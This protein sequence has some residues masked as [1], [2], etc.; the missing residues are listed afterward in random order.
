MRSDAKSLKIPILPCPKSALAAIPL[1]ALAFSCGSEERSGP[2]APPPIR[3]R[4]WDDPGPVRSSDSSPALLIVY[5]VEGLSLPNLTS[6]TRFS[7][8]VDPPDSAVRINGAETRI[9]EGGVFTGLLD[10]EP[11]E[12]RFSFEARGGEGVTTVERVVT[13]QPGGGEGAASGSVGDGKSAVESGADLPGASPAATSAAGHPATGYVDHYL[14]T[15]LK[16]PVG[17]ERFGNLINGTPLPISEV[18]RDRVR[19]DFGRGWSGWLEREHVSLEP[20]A[21][22]SPLPA[23]GAPTW[24]IER[25]MGETLVLTWRVEAP[26][27][28]VFETRPDSVTVHLPGAASVAAA[29]L[30]PPSGSGFSSVLIHEGG[31][32][33]SPEIVIGFESGRLFGYGAEFD[34]ESGYSIRVRLGPAPD[35]IRPEAPLKGLRVMIDAGHG[36]ADQSAI[37][38]SGLTEADVNL[39]VALELG[40]RLEE[41]GAAVAQTRR[42][43]VTLD[44]DSRVLM[45][46]EWNP[47]LFISIHH[48]AV[49]MEADPMT[50]SGPIMF[51][52]Y[53]QSRDIA[54]SLARRLHELWGADDAAAPRVVRQ[55]FRVNRNISLCPSVLV[56]GGFVCNPADEIRLRDSAF[57][58]SMAGELAAGV[59]DFLFRPAAG[60]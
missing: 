9:Y 30:E 26:V 33:A 50:D 56:E 12:N 29:A 39:Y 25:R 13:R 1:L 38:P 36:G 18:T 37:G 21:A 23:L 2:D 42:E 17:W 24:R 43:D 53:E 19:A 49:A 51:Y 44:L 60:E 7:G 14:A 57:L 8:R 32:V 3:E 15:F 4:L 54:E 45:A 27:A 46:R 48:N 28:A 10:L 6:R 35:F 5:P 16:H 40:R 22:A 58:R 41:R 55:N 59:E 31:D 47:D 34:S 52:H 11:G 20:P